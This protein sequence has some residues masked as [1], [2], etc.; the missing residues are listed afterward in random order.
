MIKINNLQ[1]SVHKKEILKWVSLEFEIWKNYLLAWKNVSGKS[2]LCSFLM[3][4]PKYEHVSGEVK[5]DGEDLLSLS[6]E[7][8]S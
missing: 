7:E 1:V 5:L 6:P 4:H 2:T 8:R 3:W